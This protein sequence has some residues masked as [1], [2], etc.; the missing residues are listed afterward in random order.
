MSAEEIEAMTLREWLERRGGRGA[1]LSNDLVDRLE[2]Y[3]LNVSNLSSVQEV[4]DLG[5]DGIVDI[6]L[7]MMGADNEEDPGVA[8]VSKTLRKWAS[9]EPAALPSP[10]TRNKKSPVADKV[11][12]K[13]GPRSMQKEMM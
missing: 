7:A 8:F 11:P 13:K 2:D 1:K 6:F 9:S 3:I 10:L 12:D 4:L 5:D